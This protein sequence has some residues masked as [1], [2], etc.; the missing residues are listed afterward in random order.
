MLSPNEYILHN[1]KESNRL[2][3]L[4]AMYPIGAV[5]LFSKV[6]AIDKGRLTVWLSSTTK[7]RGWVAGLWC[8]GGFEMHLSEHM[9]VH[10]GH[11]FARW[12]RSRWWFGEGVFGSLPQI[13][14]LKLYGL[15]GP[16]SIEKNSQG[17]WGVVAGECEFRLQ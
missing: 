5:S 15:N 1:S 6:P 4:F 3:C 8:A 11:H 10:A 9:A 16:A 13:N 7:K 2:G 14:R 12:A 17:T